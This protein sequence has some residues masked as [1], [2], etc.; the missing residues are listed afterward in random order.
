MGA[1]WGGDRHTHI[2]ICTRTGIHINYITRPGQVKAMTL[3]QKGA[4]IHWLVKFVLPVLIETA[5]GK[6]LD[7]F[8]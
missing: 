5:L 4:K 8:L 7:F 3:L 1:L 6:L 2:H